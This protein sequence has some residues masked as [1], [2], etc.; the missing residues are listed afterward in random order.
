[1]APRRSRYRAALFGALQLLATFP[2]TGSSQERIAPGLRRYVHASHAIYYSIHDD[3]LLV[4]RILGPGR[5]PM[6]EFQA[7][8]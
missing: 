4:E 3:G 8:R 1:L 6:L 2:K 7:K 5:D